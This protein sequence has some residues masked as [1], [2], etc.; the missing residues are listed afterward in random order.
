MYPQGHLTI[1]ASLSTTVVHVVNG[2]PIS[3]GEESEPPSH[4]TSA[5]IINI[6]NILLAYCWLI[7]PSCNGDGSV[8]M[9][10]HNGKRKKRKIKFVPIHVFLLHV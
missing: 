6:Y 7:V 5:I 3:E 1:K 8:A 10:A 9:P 2:L 4:I